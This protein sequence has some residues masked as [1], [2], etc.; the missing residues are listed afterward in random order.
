M[1]TKNEEEM[2]GTNAED[3][4]NASGILDLE[5]LFPIPA[6]PLPLTGEGI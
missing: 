5:F 6:V 1:D 4:G 3:G 2:V